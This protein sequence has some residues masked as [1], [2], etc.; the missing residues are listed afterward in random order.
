MIV[1]KLIGLLSV[2][3]LICLLSTINVVSASTHTEV[4]LN[5]NGQKNEGQRPIV[6]NNNTLVPIRTV[7]LIPNFKVD[8]DHPTKTVTVVDSLSKDVIKL[9]VGSKEAIIGEKKVT[10]AVPAIIKDGVTYVPFRFIAEGLKAHVEWDVNT[11]T[12]VIYKSDM[13]LSKL[14]KG[15][16]ITAGRNAILKLPRIILHDGL[17]T[18]EEGGAGGTYYFKFGEKDAFVYVYRGIAQYYQLKND[19]AWLTWEG[20][21]GSKGN[22]NKEVIPNVIPSIMGEWGS[23]PVFNGKINFFMDLWKLEQVQYGTLD[24]NGKSIFEDSKSITN[25]N[26]NI[27]FDIPSES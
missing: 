1:K 18:T 14:V 9:I 15:S 12:V 26:G 27:I 3:L 17:A 22:N 8:W 11:K 19:A 10:L 5:V 25:N 23:R 4:N 24:E 13:E 7:S 6:I 16:D 2:M 20:Q 21:V